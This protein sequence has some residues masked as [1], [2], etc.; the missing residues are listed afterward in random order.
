[1][2][3]TTVAS[4][5]APNYHNPTCGPNGECPSGL[6]CSANTCT[7][8]DAPP[9]GSPDVPIDMPSANCFGTGLDV[10]V[11]L[12]A[13]PSTD[14]HVSSDRDIDTTNDPLCTSGI[15][16]FCVIAGTSIHIDAGKR[17]GASGSRPLVLISTSDL[18]V[19]GVLDVASHL[20]TPQHSGPGADSPTC[21]AGTTALTH[22]GGYGGSF[23]TKGGNGGGMV[24]AMAGTTLIPTTLQGGCKGANGANG[25]VS[26][27]G[28]GAVDL[29]AT[30]ISISGSINA[31]G[32]SGSGGL[33]D[34]RGGGGS[35]SGG[36]IM[37]DAP[38]LTVAPTAQIFANG[39]GGGE[40]TAG[41][42][43]HDG[44][45]ATSPNAGGVGGSGG[46]TGGDGGAGG[47]GTIDGG[48]GADSTN[49]N[50]EGGG[51]GGGGTGVIKVFRAAIPSQGLV[52]PPFS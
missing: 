51:G 43:G 37:F 31:S 44:A 28:G 23:G 39:G 8:G 18:L 16:R 24:G 13:L 2:L 7:V 14:F 41:Q 52:S 38:M 19:E 25:G 35:G 49:M 1:M 27:H 22:G 6:H 33:A 36:M 50:T 34:G 10:L 26:G 3:V 9:D 15:T 20:Q 4:C 32:E 30:S 40:G 17:L 42:N 12:P 11:C 45:D 47:F 48:N 29:I 46:T 5:F 21:H